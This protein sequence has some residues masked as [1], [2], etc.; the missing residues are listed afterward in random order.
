LFPKAIHQ[1]DGFDAFTA[2]RKT[3]NAVIR[4]LEVLSEATKHIP[5]NFRRKHPV[6]TEKK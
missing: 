5:A 3:V 6:L 1:W 4:S 2:D